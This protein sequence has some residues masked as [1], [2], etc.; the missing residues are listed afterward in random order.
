MATEED[1]AV[2]E[3]LRIVV[4]PKQSKERLD[5]YLTHQVQNATRNKVQKA[6]LDGFVLVNGKQVR[7]SHPISPGEIIEVILPGPA[8]PDAGPENIP[9][10]V[11]YE[12]DHLM[13]VN[14]AAG[15]VTHPAH[16]N[17]TGTLVNA[18]LHHARSLSKVNT[19]LRPGIVHRLDKDTT[20]L[21][22]IAKTDI[23]HH[24]LARQFADH[25]IDREYRAIVWGKFKE[26][27]G[28]IE[29]KLGRSKRDRK[30]VAVTAEGKAA[31]TEFEVIG[32][33]EFLSYVKLALRTGR[34]HQIR[35]HLAHIG[36]PVFGD[37][38]YGGRSSTWGGIAG[39]KVQFVERL[40]KIISRQALHAR[41]IGFIHPATRKRMKFDSDLPGDMTEVL[42][43]IGG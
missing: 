40:L 30:K 16:G 32:Q 18:L 6:I 7:P 26:R 39:K 37:P 35:V 28:V 5:V 38:T 8:R 17:Y 21:L 27:K 14:K 12:D 9:L 36:H 15:M 23:A 29:A 22:V 3:P 2:R 31:V 42:K 34:T 25:T 10:D 11:V 43:K 20:G 4:P 13:V 19:E 33:F 1:A 24:I 41:T